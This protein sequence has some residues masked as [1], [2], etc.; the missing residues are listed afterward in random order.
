MIIVYTLIIIVH[1]ANLCANYWHYFASNMFFTLFISLLPHLV[2]RFLQG[3]HVHCHQE[4][5]LNEFDPWY[6]LWHLFAQLSTGLSSF[7]TKNTA[8]INVAKPS[9]ILTWVVSFAR[10]WNSVNMSC[11]VPYFHSAPIHELF[12]DLR[13][14]SR[15]GFAALDAIIVCSKLRSFCGS[16]M[17]TTKDK[18]RQTAALLFTAGSSPSQIWTCR[19]CK[20]K[21]P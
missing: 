18:H 8:G 19:T 10:T 20:L 11:T 16:T 7:I 21:N 12:R 4:P 14:L 3:R 17:I 6:S 2:A 5:S 1:V 13:R 15:S 9:E